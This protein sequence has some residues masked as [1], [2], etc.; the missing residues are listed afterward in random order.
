[1]K[2]KMIF[3]FIALVIF[4]ICFT[5]SV[6]LR[7]YFYEQSL[8]KNIQKIRVGM[9][10]KEVIEILGKPSLAEMSDISGEYWCYDTDSIARTI[11]PQP[12]IRCGYLL[13]EMS[14]AVNGHVVKVI[15]FKD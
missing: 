10:E 14:S 1:M 13:L 11:E 2:R 7:D 15:G 8:R 3:T 9:T 5:A 6:K 4:V 12:E